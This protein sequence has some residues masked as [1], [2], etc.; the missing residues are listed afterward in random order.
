MAVSKENYYWDLGVKVLRPVQNW[1]TSLPQMKVL[2][3]SKGT[4]NLNLQLPSLVK[5]TDLQRI[6]DLK[7]CNLL[8]GKSASP[9]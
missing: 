1:E 3:Q 4:W 8:V 7:P 2:I 9:W 6:H 5:Y